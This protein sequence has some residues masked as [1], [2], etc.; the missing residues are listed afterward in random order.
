MLSAAAQPSQS[1]PASTLL[2][3]VALPLADAV[4]LAS[5]K[6]YAA[7][8]AVLALHS[9]FFLRE[10]FPRADR[11]FE[12]SGKPES[13]PASAATVSGNGLEIPV[14]KSGASSLFR[15]TLH[16]DGLGDE[17][18]H[19]G[20]L[21]VY[22]RLYEV[23]AAQ[24]SVE[25][26]AA[27]LLICLK[28]R[29]E[30]HAAALQSF[31][32][33]QITS[34][35]C[36]RM[37]AVVDGHAGCALLRKEC[38][39]TMKKSFSDVENWGALNS[40]QFSRILKLNDLGGGSQSEEAVFWA[41]SAWVLS[42]RRAATEVDG[43]TSPEIP[44]HQIVSSESVEALVKL[45]RFPTIPRSAALAVTTSLL[46]AEYPG[47]EKYV[48]QISRAPRRHITV[49]TSPLFR[50]RRANVLTFA[51]RV[52][53]FSRVSGRMQTSARYFAN[54]LWHLVVGKQKGYV[55]LYL[56]VL[57]EESDADLFVELD[58]TL[59]I[60]QMSSAV[61]ASPDEAPPIYRRELK[62]ATFSRSGQRIGFRNM[63]S[64]DDVPDFARNDMLCIGASMRLRGCRDHVEAIDDLVDHTADSVTC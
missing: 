16:V 13:A 14:S 3:A 20:W 17:L 38:L 22:D 50:P 47:I 6:T 7:H 61:N 58:F 15:V 4:V 27:A 45:V 62:R 32:A 24:I 37:L 1:L 23:P 30:A 12:E 59:Y 42:R 18:L 11:L 51:D 26:A 49:E 48:A 52:S 46:V 36:T 35:N 41:V 5:G 9:P 57:S 33:S 63:M 60:A 64:L 25:T 40:R 28:Y 8:R 34:A 19:A 2:S 39:T 21:A 31:I 43:N 10:A 44:G 55:E 56:G 53:S 54:C 29:F